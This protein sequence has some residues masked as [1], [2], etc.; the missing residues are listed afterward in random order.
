MASLASS[1]GIHYVQS[2]SLQISDKGPVSSPRKTFRKKARV[3]TRAQPDKLGF[4]LFLCLCTEA[5]PHSIG[6]AT[7]CKRAFEHIHY[8]GTVPFA[9]LRNGH[10]SAAHSSGLLRSSPPHYWLRSSCSL[11]MRTLVAGWRS[12]DHP[13]HSRLRHP[14]HISTI[15]R[16]RCRHPCPRAVPGRAP[17]YTGQRRGG[18]LCRSRFRHLTPS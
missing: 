11:P 1:R 4:C 6:I 16:G 17:V 8:P 18:R 5:R 9:P 10:S 7:V 3:T 2:E 13:C 14:L 15:D 12:P